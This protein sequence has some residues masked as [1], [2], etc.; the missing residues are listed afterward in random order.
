MNSRPVSAGLTAFVLLDLVCRAASAQIPDGAAVFEDAC[1]TCHTSAPADARTPSAAALRALTP[2]AILTALTT[3]PMRIVGDSLTGVQRLAV[4]ALLGRSAATGAA[5]TPAACSS[6]PPVSSP[7]TG[8]IWNGWGAGVRNMRFQP[9]DHAGLSVSDVPRLR[10]EWA[11]G[12]ADTRSARSQPTVAGNRLLVSGENRDVYSLDPRTGC[13]HW[14]FRAQA[15]VR[16]AITVGRYGGDG[17]SGPF[18]AYLADTAANV[19]ALD[20]VTGRQIWTRRVDD[21]PAA[22]VTGAP[23]LY[24]GRLY[25]PVAGIREEV[26]ASSLTYACCTFRG[27]VIALQAETGDLVWKTYTVDAPQ[28]RGRNSAGTERYGPAGGGV[29]NAPT[30]DGRREVLYVGTGNGYSDPPQPYTSAVLA[31]NLSTGAVRWAFQATKNDVWIMGCPAETAGDNCPAQAGPD[32]DFASSPIL[33][34]VPDGREL[35]VA[36][37]KSGVAYALD[38]DRRGAVVWQYRAGRGATGGGIQWGSAVD[39]HQAYFAVSDAAVGP[40]EAGGLHAVRLADGRRVWYTPPPAPACG[41][42][43]PQCHG[44]QSAAITALPGVVFSGSSDGAMRAFASDSGRILWEF[45][46]NREFQTVNGVTA[47]GGSIDAAGPVVV[48]GMLYFNSGYF[49]GRPGNV[50]LAFAVE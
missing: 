24:S 7:E 26:Q 38:P 17:A 18:A 30:I 37:Q 13:T 32:F 27:S 16:A 22:G 39:S 8:A 33:A 10:L 40:A 45:D 23:T 14:T 5:A 48:N 42:L 15:P 11:F 2:D 3:G 12:F 28:P 6:T 44:A 36:G 4:A 21:H 20:L 46:T 1:A 25:V 31:L 49:I 41:T 34:G 47:A 35:I 50:L 29:W 43:G 9:A 19:Y